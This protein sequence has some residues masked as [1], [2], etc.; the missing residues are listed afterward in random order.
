M[1]MVAIDMPGNVAVRSENAGVFR[2]FE[3]AALLF[4]AFRGFAWEAILGNRVVNA[5]NYVPLEMKLVIGVGMI[6]QGALG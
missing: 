2:I 1:K 3:V 6:I 4:V 5:S